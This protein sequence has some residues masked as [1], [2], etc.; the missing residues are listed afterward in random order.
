MVMLV[1]TDLGMQKGKIAAQCGH[2]VLGAYHVAQSSGNPWLQLWEQSGAMKIALKELRDFE[3]R[4][5]KREVSCYLVRDAGHTQVAPHSRT[6]LALGPAPAEQLEAGFTQ[7]FVDGDCIPM[8]CRTSEQATGEERICSKRR[9]P[10]KIRPR[11]QRDTMRISFVDENEPQVQGGYRYGEV[12]KNLEHAIELLVTNCERLMPQLE[13]E[14]L[15]RVYRFTEEVDEF[16]VSTAFTDRR[17]A[18]FGV[19]A[20]VRVVAHLGASIR[21][22]WVCHRATGLCPEDEFPEKDEDEADDEE[23]L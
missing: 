22:G 12:T 5:S 8:S 15:T 10:K 14:I 19:A 11:Q 1:R 3:V 17:L 7:W 2:A 6:V 20:L 13:E 23:D 16:R 18:P 4:A 9:F 21:P